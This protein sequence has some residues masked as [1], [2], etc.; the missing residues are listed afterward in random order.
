MLR[1]IAIGERLL[2]QKIARALVGRKVYLA[3]FTSVQGAISLLKQDDFSLVLVD[4]SLNNTESICALIS[5]QCPVAIALIRKGPQTTSGNQRPLNVDGTVSEDC[6]PAELETRLQDIAR[7]HK[8]QC[9][10]AEILIIEDDAQ[11]QESLILS[12]NIYWPEAK[13]RSARSGEEGLEL[14]RRQAPDAILLDLGLPGMSGFETMAELRRFCEAPVIVITANSEEGV[15]NQALKLGAKEYLTKPFRQA[16]LMSRA[17]EH[18]QR[19]ISER[20]SGR[21]TANAWSSLIRS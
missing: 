17:I 19:E 12:F 18:I 3:C 1:I 5:Q 20:T 14:A 10:T 15:R 11:I 2:T 21:Q 6:P 16:E 4:A 7:R 8:R 13:L 9:P